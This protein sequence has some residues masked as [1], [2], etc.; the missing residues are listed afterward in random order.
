MALRITRGSA[1]SGTAVRKP[2]IRRSLIG[3]KGGGGV[4]VLELWV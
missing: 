2:R 1:G 4:R 3:P